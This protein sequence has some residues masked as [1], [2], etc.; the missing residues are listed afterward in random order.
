MVRLFIFLAAAQLALFVLALISCL[1][2]ER[3]RA[4]PR[5]L[6]V[7]FI[8]VIPLVG[9]ISYFV[10]GR[11]VSPPVE[12][13]RTMAP[14][15]PFSIIVGFLERANGF[16]LPFTPKVREGTQAELNKLGQA[17]KVAGVAL[18]EYDASGKDIGCNV[19]VRED[20]LDDEI[21]SCQHQNDRLLNGNKNQHARSGGVGF[22]SNKSQRTG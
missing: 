19:A 20:E 17:D 15:W 9:P 8:V 12:L 10:W 11:P 18:P 1:A 5:A 4:L 22:V 16:H 7:L 13:V 2:A 21:I 3:V 6:W 14:P